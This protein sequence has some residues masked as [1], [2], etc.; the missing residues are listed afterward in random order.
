MDIFTKVTNQISYIVIILA[1]FLLGYWF[2]LLYIPM[3]LVVYEPEFLPVDSP[4][5]AD[6]D[7]VT[8][9]INVYCKYV[10]ARVEVHRQLENLETGELFGVPSVVSN[11][12]PGCVFDISRTFDVPQGVPAGTYRINFIG[13]YYV[14]ALRTETINSYSEEFIIL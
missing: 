7:S 12:P 1:L 3:N 6:G 10:P 13:V 9:H 14:N 4:V 11:L 8:Y 2:Y 5:Y